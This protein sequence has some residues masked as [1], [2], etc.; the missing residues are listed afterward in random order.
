MPWDL[1]APLYNGSAI[2]WNGLIIIAG[3][4]NEGSDNDWYEL[5]II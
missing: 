2:Y 1:P 5:L 3:G 4:N